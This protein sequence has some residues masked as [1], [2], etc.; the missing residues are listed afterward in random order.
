MDFLED[1]LQ[2]LCG[3]SVPEQVVEQ[4]DISVFFV[5]PEPLEEDFEGVGHKACAGL[6]DYVAE[7]G[8]VKFIWGGFGFRERGFGRE[9]ILD[10]V[11]EVRLGNERAVFGFGWV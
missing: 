5:F 10:D 4:D 1:I 6:T 2:V 7:V 9:D 8:I 3:S 11:H